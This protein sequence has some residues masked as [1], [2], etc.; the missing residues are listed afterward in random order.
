MATTT[1]NYG[2]DV[3][4]STDYVKDG[5]TAIETLGDDIDASLFSI[6]NGKNVGWSLISG[7][8]LSAASSGT[9]SG[10][11]NSTFDNYKV[12]MNGVSSVGNSLSLRVGS[13]AVN[14]NYNYNIIYT[15]NGS[16]PA[17]YG[18]ANTTE[19]AFGGGGTVA[20]ISEAI[21]VNPNK[22]SATMFQGQT[23]KYDSTTSFTQITYSAYHSTATAYTDLY[24]F[25]SSG[26]YTGSIRIYGLRNS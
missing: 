3:P 6:T 18:L 14:T 11:F 25:V 8:T 12:V 16:V 17:H 23:M 2:W 7:T 4:T 19:F 24:W 1:P 22:A 9:I 21:L 5:A 20:S 13:S 15:S 26:T 10:C